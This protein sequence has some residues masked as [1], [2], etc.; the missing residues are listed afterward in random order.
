MAIDVDA[1]FRSVTEPALRTRRG[2]KWRRY[3]ADVLPAWVADMDFPPAPCIRDALVEAIARGDLGYPAAQVPELGERFRTWVARR[4]GWSPDPAL[5]RPTADVVKGIEACLLAFSRP[6]DGVVV[7]TPIYPPFLHTI[8]SLGRRVV[9][10]PLQDA[11][12]DVDHLRW[13]VTTER[14]AVLLVCH[15]HNPT[16]HLFTPGELTAIVGIARDA[17][18]TIVSDEIHADLVLEPGSTFTPLQTV[19]DAA[20]R[21]VTVTAASKAFNFAGLRCAITVAGSPRLDEALRALPESTRHG[22]GILGIEATLA[23]WTADGE[24]WLEAC[25]RV[26]RA[27]RDLALERI[28][29]WPAAR[30]VPPEATYLLWIDLTSWRPT[31][32]RVLLHDARVALSPGEDFGPGGAGHVRLNVATSPTVLGA[33]LD[34]LDGV[35][36]T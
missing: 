33:V 28:G 8:E 1:C 27:N 5:V 18:C 19:D 23:A 14:P 35:L 11:A 3:P 16:G 32:A 17:G 22:V 4:Q 20:A 30:V 2:A 36:A 25:I 12:L 21:T 31:P 29:R 10:N 6:G 7:Q 26:L 24:E 13:V 15:P 34:R 9:P